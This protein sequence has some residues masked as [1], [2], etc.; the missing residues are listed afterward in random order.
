MNRLGRELLR[1]F[2][3]KYHYHYLLDR[4]ELI[5][6]ENGHYKIISGEFAKVFAEQ[7]Y[8]KPKCLNDSERIEFLKLCQANHTVR[9]SCEFFDHNKTSG[10]INFSNGVY[11]LQS[12]RLLPHNPSIP[13]QYILPHPYQKGKKSPTMDKFIEAFSCGCEKTINVIWEHLGWIIMRGSPID[14][15]KALILDGPGENGK[16]TFINIVKTLVGEKNTSAVSIAAVPKNRFILYQMDG[17]L[18]NFAEEEPQ[19]IFSSTGEFKGITGGSPIYIERKGKDGRSVVIRA[20]NIITYNEMPP[21]SDSSKGMRNRLLIVPCGQDYTKNP[22]L[23]IS[24][25]EKKIKKEAQ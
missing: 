13:F 14:F 18:V 17:K 9:D 24:N 7:H 10:K 6:W 20:K 21:L 19:S 25:I 8:N 3:H 5:I 4:K 11:D 2:R 15:K 22:H 16:S 23:K 12:D 1:F